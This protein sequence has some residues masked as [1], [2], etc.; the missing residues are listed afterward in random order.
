M[1][2]ERTFKWC[3]LQTNENFCVCFVV[4]VIQQIYVKKKT[5]QKK[6]WC[7]ILG[8]D[9]TAIYGVINIIH[10]CIKIYTLWCN[11]IPHTL[12]MHYL[13]QYLVVNITDSVMYPIG[14]SCLYHIYCM[15]SD[16]QAR[17]NSIYWIYSDWQ[18][19][20]NSI[21]CMYSDWQAWA[22]SIYV[23]RLTGLCKQYL[24]WVRLT[25]LSKQC[26]PRWAANVLS[27]T[28]QI[29]LCIQL[30]LVAYTIFT[31]CIQTDRPEQTVFTVCIQTD[32]PEQ[33]VF[34]Y[35]DWQA[36]ANS[37][38]CI[39]SDWQAWANSVD[40]D[41][42]PQKVASHQGLHCLSIIQQYLDTASDIK[43]YLFKF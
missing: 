14:I 25:G 15:Y 31:V 33:T 18:A 43:L 7:D 1:G 20:A 39:Y 24:L 11:N 40:P 37:I 22:N 34:M 17:A 41:E 2:S 19:W 10:K 38:Y 23:F 30:V 32:R 8:F 3:N 29:A 13:V 35:S 4:F 21:Y 6:Q 16:W 5:T 26:R 36:W 42:L 9:N 12:S 28:L 27:W